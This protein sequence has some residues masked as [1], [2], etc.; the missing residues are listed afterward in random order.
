MVIPHHPL[1]QECSVR[2]IESEIE[3]PFFDSLR[4][5]YDLFNAWFFKCAKENR[6]CYILKVDDKITA[7]LIYHKEKS[8]S[9]NLPNISD[10]SIKICTLNL[11]HYSEAI[12]Y[13]HHI[14]R[15]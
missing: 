8:S 4:A 2:D 6:K 9:H 5:S 12:E 14:I 11:M 10:D 3:Q 13:Y 15:K 1:L 7:L